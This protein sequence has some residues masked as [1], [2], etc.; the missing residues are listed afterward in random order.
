MV[1]NF[2]EIL[3][4]SLILFSVIDIV[5]SIPI[6]IDLKKKAGGHIESGKATLVAGVLMILF[7]FVGEG[8]LGLFHL[9]VAS[10]AVAGAI[11][12]FLLGLEMILGISIFKEDETLART[13]SVV[14][15]AF[16]LIAGAGTMTTILTLKAE[17]HTANILIGIVINLILVFVVLKMSSWIEKK[18]GRGG[19][20]VLR[21]VFG[22]I[23]LAI[24]IKIFKGNLLVLS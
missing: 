2:Q 6:I 13:A 17:Y 15:I 12:I 23:L 21:K 16:P 24:A 5:G 8:L 4:V 3:S 14:P 1:L 7:L 19:E 22:I 20:A 11:V 10:F 9:D 18:I